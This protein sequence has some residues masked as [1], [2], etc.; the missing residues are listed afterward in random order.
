MKSV[1]LQSVDEDLKVY[2]VEVNGKATFV[3]LRKL[4]GSEVNTLNV[5]REA[6]RGQNVFYFVTRPL[7]VT[8]RSPT[9]TPIRL[10]CMP[11][12]S[13][14]SLASVCVSSFEL[15]L[16]ST[17]RALSAKG[18]YGVAYISSG[19]AMFLNRSISTSTILPIDSVRV[20]SDIAFYLLVG[21]MS[22]IVRYL[23]TQ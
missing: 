14:L 5:F 1:L 9:W 18:M 10:V 22:L 20:E 3:T 16:G 21:Y 19:C 8:K 2:F 23:T 15:V 13:E 17:L 6:L 4:T 11:V 12:L 7:C